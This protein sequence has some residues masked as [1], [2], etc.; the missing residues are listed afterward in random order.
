MADAGLKAIE[1]QHGFPGRWELPRGWRWSDIGEMAN[2]V[3][4]GRSPSY[5]ES[6]GIRVINQK[7]V[8]WSGVQHEHAKQT[9]SNRGKLLSADQYIR[10]GDILW[11]ST[12]TGT[13]GRASLV[14]DRDCLEPTVVDS[15]VTIVRPSDRL[16]PAWL[17]YWL[18]MPLVQRAVTG[19]GSTNQVELSRATV[20]GMFLPLP[21]LETQ[22]GIAARI[23]ELFVE[24]DDGEEELRRA[25][26]ELVTY[27][28]SLL[29]AAVTGELT[30]DWRA[31]SG[32]KETGEEFLKRIL[33]ERRDRWA[34]DPKNRGKQYKE[35]LKPRVDSVPALPNGWVWASLDQLMAGIQAGLNVK[36]LGRPPGPDEVGIVK[37]S[38]VT[39]DDFD[40]QASKTLPPSAPVLEENVIRTGDLL[41]S[42]ANTL[43]LVGAP[44]I[45][46]PIKRRLVLSDKVLRLMVDERVKAWIYFVL[47]SALGRRQVE[48]A[49]TGNQLSMRNISQDSL[50]RLAIP[51]P[52]EA[53]LFQVVSAVEVGWR[54]YSDM[55]AGLWGTEVGTLRQSILAAAFRGE[56]AQ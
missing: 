30:A 36:A 9:S 20:T 53:E 24:I 29:K 33:D 56:L 22:R 50:R 6:G 39:W 17:H 43:E 2:Y 42:R 27:R 1:G 28:K 41:I 46:G 25:R 44:A 15:H 14:R 35:P 40:E 23:D 16:D 7:C 48:S 26:L 34:A 32:P 13:I 8:R 5:V 49:A 21:P 31:A 52:G 19:V 4:R 3:S 55:V 54:A 51:L 38:A 11:N 47:K 12:G 10:P 18:Q 37:I 45:V